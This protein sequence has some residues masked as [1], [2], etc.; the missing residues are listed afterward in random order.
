MLTIEPTGAVLGAT[1]HGIDARN[2]STRAT[3]ARILHA[4]GHHGVLRF[5]DQ[6]LD[7]GTLRTFSE[8]FGEIQGPSSAPEV[9]KDANAHVGTLS[10]LKEDG[11]LYR[12]AGCRAGLAHRHVVSRRDGLR[13]RAVRHP[14]SAPERRAA[15]AAPSSPTC[16][17]RTMRCR[18]TSG[19]RLADATATHNF[20]KFW[21]H[22]RRDKASTR[23]PMTDEQQRRRPPVV[24][25]L[26]LTH[27]ITGSEVL[28]C[29]PGYTTRINELSEHDSDEMLE[30]LFAH[31]LEPALPLHPY[32]DRE[33]PAGVGPPRHHPSRDRRLRRRTRSG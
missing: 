11:K 10:N 3:S 32:L 30:Y 14:H 25:P 28:Y 24:H 15:R 17:R 13:E 19:R 22:M 16:T 21:E 6:Q 4:L 20:E 29:N 31:Q 23:P 12:L 18:P 5:P 26:F 7:M 1:I 8:R 9:A 2:P 27:P 33:R